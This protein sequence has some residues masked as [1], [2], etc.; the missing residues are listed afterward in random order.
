MRD[1]LNGILTFIVA[2]SLTD[3]EFDT[4][5][6]TITI[7]DQSTYDDLA[8]ILQSRESVSVYQDRLLNFYLAKGVD[9]APKSTA[10][11]NILIG[12]VLS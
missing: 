7:Y 8:R 4:V 2:T 1:F 10:K 9:V 5:Q 3:D 6:S 11:S 12:S